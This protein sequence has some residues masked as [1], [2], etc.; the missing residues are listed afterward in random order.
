MYVL[1]LHW[2]YDRPEV[3]DITHLLKQGSVRRGSVKKYHMERVLPARLF[4]FFFS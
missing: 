3:K 2:P 4:F 1:N